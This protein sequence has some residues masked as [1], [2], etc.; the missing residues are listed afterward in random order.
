MPHEVTRQ[1][2]IINARGLHAR[3]ATKLVQLAGKFDCSILLT[4]PDGQSANAKSVMG[5]LLLCG[6]VGTVLEARATG[7]QAE[8]AIEAIGQ[9]ITSRFGEPE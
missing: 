3:A 2:T 4:G 1:F 5:V 9:L 7:P 8:A 6:C